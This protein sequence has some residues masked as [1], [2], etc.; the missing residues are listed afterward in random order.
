MGDRELTVEYFLKDE[1]EMRA[2]WG[3]ALPNGWVVP[4]KQPDRAG[5]KR[6]RLASQK[7]YMVIMMHN[8]RDGKGVNKF[9]YTRETK[10]FAPARWSRRSRSLL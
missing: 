4:E 1:S 7:G 10:K 8:D 2:L 3:G 9:S 5:R 6:E